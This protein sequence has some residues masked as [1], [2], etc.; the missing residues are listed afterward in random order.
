MVQQ[1]LRRLAF[2]AARRLAGIKAINPRSA[3]LTAS[4]SGKYAYMSGSR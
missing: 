1:S 2:R 3:M 4:A